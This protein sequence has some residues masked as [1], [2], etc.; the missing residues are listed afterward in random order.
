MDSLTASLLTFFCCFVGYAAGQWLSRFLPEHHYQ[1]SDAR[2]VLKSATG[3]IATLV[4]LVLG[5]LVSS[6][7]TTFDRTTDAMNDG[8][9]KLVQIDR[10]LHKFGPETAPARKNLRRLVNEVVTRIEEP[11]ANMRERLK[12]NESNPENSLDTQLANPIEALVPQNE[13]QTRL[14]K[15]LGD[16]L[17][18]LSDNRWVMIERATNKLPFAFLILLFFW[19]ATLFAGFGI[20]SPRNLTID[21]AFIIC[22]LSMAGA[23]YLIIEMNEPL[24][25][26]VRVSADP[27][28]T[29]LSVMGE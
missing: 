1:Q 27:L 25:G 8:G 12:L 24:D 9:A 21:C 15:R 20:L 2:D 29:A 23:V 16:L 18:N 5:L 4:A 22:A 14:V 19:L 11:N 10:L 26:T 7:K 17:S 13:Q 28:K 6:A 3:M